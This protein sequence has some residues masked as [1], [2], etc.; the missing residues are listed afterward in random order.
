MNDE[1]LQLVRQ[2]VAKAKSDWEAVEILS[3]HGTCPRDTVCFHCQQY[4]EKLLKALL[5]LH[6]IEAPRT[7]NLRRL[8]QLAEPV[9]GEL[10]EL[11]C[12]SDTLTLHGVLSRYPDEWREISSAEMNEMIELAREFGKILLPRLEK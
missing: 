6:G 7:H 1:V 9:A 12:P 5:T 11:T 8:I 3:S 4:V 2:W 10:S